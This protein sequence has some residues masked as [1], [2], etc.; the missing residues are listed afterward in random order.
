M[1]VSATAQP[2][3]FD[4]RSGTRQQPAHRRIV[5]GG[6][7]PVLGVEVLDELAEDRLVGGGIGKDVRVIPVDVGQ[8]R[9]LRGEM[10]EF[11]SRIE[12][13]R[14]VLVALENEFP[15]GSPGGRCPQVLDRHPE[16]EPRIAARASKDPSDQTGRGGFSSAARHHDP[17]ALGSELTPV[18]GFA[19]QADAEAPRR[20]RLGI[21]LAD[22]VALHHEVGLA[23]AGR[24]ARRVAVDPLDACVGQDVG[25][26]WVRVLVR[27]G[28]LVAELLGDK[29]QS[30]NRVAA[31]SDE[32]NP[33]QGCAAARSSE[34]TSSAARGRP[35]VRMASTIVR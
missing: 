27:P 29:R 30:G 24:I 22:L 32:V 13:G 26:R 15:T 6:N 9:E 7:Q 34:T 16:P 31:D 28:D 35:R 18:L 25:G 10:Q 19:D 12:H 2:I 20:R 3:R 23:P 4:V 1:P 8:H 21:V 11:W 5:R 17:K 14:R 33:H